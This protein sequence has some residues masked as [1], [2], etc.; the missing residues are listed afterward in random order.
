MA[1]IDKYYTEDRNEAVI[2]TAAI[3][4]MKDVLV[5]YYLGEKLTFD[6]CNHLYWTVDE[7]KKLPDEDFKGGLPIW[8]SP[9]YMDFWLW[10]SLK[11]Y[12][13]VIKDLKWKYDLDDEMSTADVKSIM[14][15]DAELLERGLHFKVLSGYYPNRRLKR[16]TYSIEAQME[17]DGVYLWY[18][19][20]H[21][22]WSPITL[23]ID[24][25][26]EFFK[27][28][29]ITTKKISKLVRKMKFPIGAIVKFRSFNYNIPDLVIKIT[30]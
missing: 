2:L 12:P 29:Y 22:T 24:T 28:N 23:P 21:K 3:S 10:C 25:N 14:M 20:K 16:H 26:M 15:G 1:A 30:K 5:C 18:N 11:S 4:V 8:N 6:P 13:G 7:L 27:T 17:N 19:M 9:Y